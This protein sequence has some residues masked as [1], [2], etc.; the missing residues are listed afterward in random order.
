MCYTDQWTKLV[1]KEAKPGGFHHD[2]EA[3]LRVTKGHSQ[4]RS[5]LVIDLP[6]WPEWASSPLMHTVIMAMSI[7]CAYKMLLMSAPNNAM[8]QPK[9]VEASQVQAGAWDL[10][11]EFGAGEMTSVL[12]SVSL[13]RANLQ[14]SD[15]LGRKK[16][17]WGKRPAFRLVIALILLSNIFF[18]YSMLINVSDVLMSLGPP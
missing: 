7:I 14:R 2:L 15:G 8:W 17:E 18:V 16:Q 6:D 9:E 5:P 3:G 4:H 1:N 12:T 10:E 13:W 11:A